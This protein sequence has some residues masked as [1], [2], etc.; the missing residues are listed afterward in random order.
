MPLSPQGRVADPNECG[1]EG[2]VIETPACLTRW[3]F[4]NTAMSSTDGL[5]MN[6]DWLENYC[7]D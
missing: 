3:F 4:V 1:S 7:S 2:V 5:D 6:Y